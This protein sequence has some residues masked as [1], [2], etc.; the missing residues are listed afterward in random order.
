MDT[1][2]QT[3]FWGAF[4]WMKMFE[5]RLKFHWSLFLRVQLTIFQHWFRKW[6]GAV[7]ATNH[8]LNQWW[9]DY[10]PI[11]AP[12]GLNELTTPW[13]QWSR[14]KVIICTQ[15]IFGAVIGHIMNISADYG[16][17]SLFIQEW[18]LC[19]I[20]TA[21]WTDR[22]SLRCWYKYWPYAEW[23]LSWP[24]LTKF[25]RL[26]VHKTLCHIPIIIHLGAVSA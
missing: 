18:N 2:S 7:Q 5:F 26:L 23:F 12:L 22:H 25:C 21:V 8:Y 16:L 24:S 6:L 14:D 4:S 11:Y 19:H 13:T 1:I 20:F 10:R 17:A 3:T 15:F 9:L